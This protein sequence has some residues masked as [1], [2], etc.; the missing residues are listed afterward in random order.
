MA[1]SGGTFTRTNGVNTGATTW[2]TDAAAGVKIRADRHDTHDQDLATGINQCINKDGSN[3]ATQLNVDNIRVDG[4]TISSTNANG[5]INLTPN[6][7]GKVVI[8]ESGSA[9][10]GYVSGTRLYLN[11]LG[12]AATVFDV[13]T[14][15]TE[16]AFESVGPT[17]SSATNIWTSMDVMPT[18]AKAVIIKAVATFT[19]NATTGSSIGVYGKQTGQ[20]DNNR[21]KLCS[22]LYEAVASGDNVEITHSG[23]LIP[24]DSSRRFDISWVATGDS[25]RGVEIWLQ[26]FLCQ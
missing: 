18:D 23:L 25:A 3:A 22:F 10:S 8:S 7:T 21:N 13:V 24:L 5:D 11:V 14:N 20:A 1:W 9:V 26:G 4:N 19:T 6:G 15:V 2:A 16:S 12:G 17:G